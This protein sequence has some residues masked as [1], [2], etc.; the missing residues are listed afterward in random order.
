MIARAAYY[1][2]HEL[3]DGKRASLGRS[4]EAQARARPNQIAL[5]FEDRTFTFAELDQAANRV[6][7][8]LGAMG[9]RRGD[10]LALLMSNRPE[11]LAV[12]LG[13]NKLGVAVALLDTSLGGD[14]LADAVSTC[15][16]SYV[17][18]GGE[19]VSAL[20]AMSDGLPVSLGRVLVWREA[21]EG[22]VLRGAVELGARLHQAPTVDPRSTAERRAAEPC[23]FID[24]SGNAGHAKIAR[25]SNG[26]MLGAASLVG[27]VV[28][29]IE[30]SDVVYG[31]GL[32]LHHSSGF[33]VG[34]CAALVGG[35]AYAIRRRFSASQHWDDVARYGATV[36]TY[37]G[38]LCRHLLSAAP[39]PLE[40]AHRLRAVLGAGL[41][42]D[43]WV[44]FEERFAIPFVYELQGATE[45]DVGSFN[46]EGEAGMM[47]RLM[48]RQM[49]A[50]LPT[51]DLVRPRG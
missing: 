4:L 9:A 1:S 24:T 22:A 38:E 30:P 12:V 50:Y 51:G 34:F 43:D 36:C 14:A 11:H 27:R 10:V 20:A 7:H 21:R 3:R 5:Y 35:G 39:H 15:G 26:Q 19:H 13:A 16:P 23:I 32:P 6:A 41:R 2:V 42:P 17:L 29:A 47:G 8:T 48:P 28:A 25:M 18:V 33:I 46:L 49:K 44:G 45:G 37:S 31:A 40:K